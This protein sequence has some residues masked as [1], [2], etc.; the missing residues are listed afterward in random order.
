M[1]LQTQ[2]YLNEGQNFGPGCLKINMGGN[3]KYFKLIFLYESVM[4]FNCICF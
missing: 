2:V 4:Q 3:W 1:I